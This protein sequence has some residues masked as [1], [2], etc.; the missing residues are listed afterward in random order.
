M[1]F[2]TKVERF[3]CGHNRNPKKEVNSHVYL[4]HL[5]LHRVL[6]SENGYTEIVQL[7]LENKADPNLQTEKGYSALY[8]ASDNGFMEIVQLLL[9]YDADP[10]LQDE[11]GSSSLSWASEKGYNRFAKLLLNK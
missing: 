11:D 5:D 9:L 6:S 8:F 2:L 7:L 1:Q 3:L 4:A 10:N